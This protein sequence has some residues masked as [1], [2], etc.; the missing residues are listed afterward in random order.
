MNIRNLKILTLIATLLLV[1]SV[2]SQ[3]LFD[4][5]LSRDYKP[6][7]I[8]KS[9]TTIGGYPIFQGGRIWRA[10][11]GKTNS[12]NI[13]LKLANI[14]LIS[15]I[16]NNYF[17]EI[18][19]MVNLEQRNSYFTSDI[20]TTSHLYKLNNG[21][22]KY[23]NCLTIDPYMV[24]I[25]GKSINTFHINVRNSQQG[26]RIYDLNLL[27]NLSYLGFPQTEITDWTEDSISRDVKK[28]QLMEKIT[29]WAKKLQDG[30]S[31]AIEYNK[32]QNAFEDVPPISDLL[33]VE[34]MI[35][36]DSEK[37]VDISNKLPRPEEEVYQ[38][39]GNVHTVI[40]GTKLV[41][42]TGTAP[43]VAGKTLLQRLSELKELLDKGLISKD[44]YDKRSGEI[45]QEF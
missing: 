3:D 19:L 1:N 23:D 27:F 6:T 43:P 13:N 34:N 37:A 5:N 30:V 26:A 42:T 36:S 12:N 16:D 41:T 14:Q 21:G 32:P 45:I 31:K 40:K 15:P 8:I 33:P 4:N 38:G 22:G 10:L 2:Y 39:V 35:A 9:D 18:S 25:R 17:A 44:Q 20:C 24:K 7:S 29:A 11:S 28:K